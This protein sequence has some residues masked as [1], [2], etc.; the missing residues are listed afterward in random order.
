M[1]LKVAT[2]VESLNTQ[3]WAGV[4]QAG[5][6]KS[7][8]R[9]S[10]GY[11]ITKASDDAAGISIALKLNVK[12]AS[13]SKSID[14]GNQAVAMLQTAEGGIEQIANILTRLKELATQ[15]ASDNVSDTD[16][17]KLN[18]ERGDLHSE[19]NRIAQNTKYGSTSLLVGASTL[20]GTTSLTATTAGIDSVDLSGA[21]D[22]TAAYTLT[23]VSDGTNV[24]MTLQTAS[25]T[26]TL[27]YAKVSGSSTREYNFTAFGIKVT[28]NSS[29]QT[30]VAASGGFTITAGT[31][32][33]TYQLGDT[34]STFN[35]I[36]AGVNN[37]KIDVSGSVLTAINGGLVD[38]KA[39]AQ[40][41]L[42]NLDTSISSLNTERGKVGAAQNAI[43]YQVSNM[44]AMYENTKAAESTIR[45]ADFAREMADFTKY[46]IL[47]QS[48][49]AMMSQANQLPQMVMSLL[50]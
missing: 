33:F 15:S 26:Q 31:S 13:L 2:N 43:S 29:A 25:A 45:D 5:Q 48:S 32:N 4:A 8:S 18:T 41:Y 23:A 12:A 16:R 35:Q 19:I 50:Q 42:N 9:L 3:R 20:N 27:M 37:F 6:A 36:T 22:A 49:V 21:Y 7:L 44:E 30:I 38:S 1:S 46:Q 28:A 14:N 24:T 10:S 40:S 39:N 47:A 11:K 17:A 34:N